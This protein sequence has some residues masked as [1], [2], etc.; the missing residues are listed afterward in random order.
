MARLADLFYCTNL[1]ISRSRVL[2]TTPVTESIVENTVS[3]AGWLTGVDENVKRYFAER[4][5]ELN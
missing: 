1:I 2:S 5:L 3:D 4:E